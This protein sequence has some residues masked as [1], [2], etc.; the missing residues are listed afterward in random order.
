MRIYQK[1]A[2]IV[3]TLFPSIVYSQ[4]SLVL[5]NGNVIVG[6]IKNLS[7]GVMTVETGYSKNDFTIKWSGIKEVYTKGRYL[8]TLQNGDRFNGSVNSRSDSVVRI[9]DIDSNIT[10]VRLDDLV[11]LK[12]LKSDFWSRF[13]AN[14][15]L[16]FS[17]TKANDFRQ[18]TLRWGLEYLADRWMLTVTGSTLYTAQDSVE[19]TK[20]FDGAINYRYF[21]QRDW[22]L[23]A[24]VN[25]LSNTEQAIK[26]RT[27][28]SL[29]AGKFLVHTNKAYWGV[30]AGLSFNNETFSNETESRNSL[31]AY[32]GT[33]A[34]LFDIGN[35]N[36]FSRLYVFP[37]LT[38]SG[39]W[40]TDFQLDAK[41][42]LPLNF[43]IKTGLTLNYD[44]KPAVAG[45]ETDMVWMVTFGWEL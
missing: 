19:A 4:D 34:S 9:V 28:G 8:I 23:G 25:F 30:G 42:D 43:Y 35:L 36:L 41:Y 31:E 13:K 14:I 40:R 3:F 7:N 29:G 37:S 26:L 17:Y 6:E 22:F 12:G 39:R 20:R 33:E 1:A 15:D 32:V 2:L 5:K 18:F 38:E 10:D 27:T 44:N 21:L 11:Y 24:S 16:G 45:N